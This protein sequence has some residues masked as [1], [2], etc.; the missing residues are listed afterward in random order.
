MTTRS[1]TA[2]PGTE[3]QPARDAKVASYVKGSHAARVRAEQ[4]ERRVDLLAL[5]DVLSAQRDGLNDQL[6]DIGEALAM[7]SAPNV[8]SLKAAE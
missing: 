8:V 6:S 5:H 1:T 4:D 7:L 3:A 2:V